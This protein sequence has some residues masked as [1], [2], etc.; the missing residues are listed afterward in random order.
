MA[1]GLPLWRS[2]VASSSVLDVS[3]A[4][5]LVLIVLRIMLN[6]PWPN[7]RF[8]SELSAAAA[9]SLPWERT[10]AVTTTRDR[11]AGARLQAVWIDCTFDRSRHPHAME[12]RRLEEANKSQASSEG[13]QV[14]ISEHL[15]CRLSRGPEANV[16][17]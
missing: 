2:K 14:Y 7:S 16:K 12:G 17:I 13:F 15:E 9:A 4:L 11:T 8:K 10:A 5:K 6:A 3:R 1:A